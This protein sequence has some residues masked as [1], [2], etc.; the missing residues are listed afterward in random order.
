MSVATPS[1]KRDVAVVE[2]S[3]AAVPKLLLEDA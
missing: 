3:A 1:K 2:V